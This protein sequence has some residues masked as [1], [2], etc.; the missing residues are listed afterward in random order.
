[1][2]AD[3]G[4]SS[5]AP[6]LAKRISLAHLAYLVTITVKGLDGA[7][8]T[9]AGLTIWITGPQRIYAFVLHFT[10]PELYE[11]PGNHAFARLLQHG[12]FTLSES[13]VTFIIIYLLVH[14]V[15]KL[16]LATVLLR[17]GGR[18]VFPVA[19]AILAGFIAFMSY[20]L[21]EH[22]SNWVLS[23]A[24]FDLFTLA[25][26]LNEWSRPP[27]DQLGLA[28]KAAPGGIGSAS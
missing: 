8:E 14:G 13:P 21:A 23:F 4:F 18:W 16:V 28:E 24:L 12:A 11:E 19:T 6:S 7:L 1:M 9:V 17:G 5:G 20:H 15:L 25:L 3:S 26:V 10:A 22:W 27:R 2:S